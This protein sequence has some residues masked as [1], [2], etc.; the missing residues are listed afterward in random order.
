M[1]RM[2]CKRWLLCWCITMFAML[3]LCGCSSNNSGVDVGDVDV[4]DIDVG[5][6]DVGNLQ[7][8][9][10]NKKL[11][12]NFESE[13][14]LEDVSGVQRFALE[15]EVGSVTLGVSE[16]ENIHIKANTYVTAYTQE[17][18][19]KIV[20]NMDVI[21]KVVDDSC[22]VS[23][24]NKSDGT[25]FWDW[26]AKEIKD[27]NVC[28]DLEILLP[29]NFFSFSVSVDCG[30]IYVAD[31]QGNMEL[32]TDTGTV[33]VILCE[34]IGSSSIDI[35]TDTG[36]IEIDLN[37][38]QIEYDKKGRSHVEAVVNEVCTLKATVDTGRINV[39]K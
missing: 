1:K 35:E 11:E 7:N 15:H 13:Y 23:I 9:K 4:G 2:Q 14:I 33:D 30:A 20:E 5:D 31:L 37:N 27:Y 34:N 18:L 36:S 22:V 28:I 16:D 39:I 6:I 25:A 8:G 10:K 17:N 26:L 38:N 12:K 21:N 32:A 24:V 19:D 3:S 29:S